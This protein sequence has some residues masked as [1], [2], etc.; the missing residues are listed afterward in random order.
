MIILVKLDIEGAL[1]FPTIVGKGIAVHFDFIFM[2]VHRLKM[3]E[4]QWIVFKG[5]HE[6]YPA[7]A[8]TAGCKS[9]LAAV[10]DESCLHDADRT[11]NTC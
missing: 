6:F 1:R 3:I 10:K 9:T 4:E 11:I 8:A 7:L 2:E 5:L